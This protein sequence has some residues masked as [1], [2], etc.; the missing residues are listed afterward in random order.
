MSSNKPFAVGIL[1]M[2]MAACT[3][4]GKEENKYRD[5]SLPVEKRVEDL[6]GKMTI[7]EKAEQASAQ[8]LF[9]KDFF[10]KRDY[11]KGHIRNIG[12]FLWE[13]NV[14][15]DAKSAAE[16][17][18]EDTRRSIEASRWGIPVLQ[19]GEALHGAQWGNA[20]CFP[21]SIARAV[22]PPATK[23]EFSRYRGTPR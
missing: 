9:Y 3:P 23:S 16:Q 11:A 15:N 6:L 18:N 21:Q 1:L 14:P 2:A 4:Q 19:H 17:I 12:H 13:G 20:T 5:A 10:E 8:L 22:A 7:E